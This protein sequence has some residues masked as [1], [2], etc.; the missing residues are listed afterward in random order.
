MNSL[1]Y[2]QAQAVTEYT[3]N[4]KIDFWKK[5]DVNKLVE[6]FHS[7]SRRTSQYERLSMLS[8]KVDDLEELFPKD[9]NVTSFD[10][11]FALT[12]E[13]SLT[14]QFTFKPIISVHYDGLTSPSIQKEFQYGPVPINYNDA[15]PVST[16]DAPVPY[17]FKEWIT[18]NWMELNINLIDDVFTASFADETSPKHK[19]IPEK[20]ITQR[21]LAYYFTDKINN[22][23]FSFVTSLKKDKASLS[24]FILHLG[25]DMNKFDHKD[26][27]S[28]SPVFEL[29][30]KNASDAIKLLAYN[31]GLRTSALKKDGKVLNEDHPVYFEYGTPCPSTC[32]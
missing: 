25:V 28:F 27:F 14:D 8:L 12:N 10:I 29:R 24:Q 3:L 5:C 1:E 4:N 22:K 20:R 31:L 32:P 30:I 9:K 11:S 16:G 13:T 6:H 26:Q 21:L 7:Y 17:E 19:S 23:L 18:Q 15:P 2:P